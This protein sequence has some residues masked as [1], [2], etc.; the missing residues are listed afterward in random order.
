MKKFLFWLAVCADIA[1]L[2]LFLYEVFVIAGII[3][4]YYPA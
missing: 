2:V 1:T 3:P 4:G